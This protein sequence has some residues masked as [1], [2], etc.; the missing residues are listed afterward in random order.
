[1]KIKGIVV[2]SHT[3]NFCAGPAALPRSVL[4]K[5]QQELL[6]WQGLGVSVMEVSHRS[7]EYQQLAKKAE[8]NFRQLMNIGQDYDV[9]FLHGGASLQ[10][11]NIPMVLLDPKKEAEYL[12]NGIWSN[13]AAQEAKRF[14]LVNQ[15]E[16]L[17]IDSNGNRSL[18]NLN[19]LQRSK[20]AVYTHYTPNETIEGLRYSEIPSAT[21]ALVADL[22]SS[23]LSEVIDINQFDLIY[24]GAQKNIG[25]A[26]A[27]IVLI[28]EDFLAT[29]NADLPTMLDYGTHTAKLFNTPP[30]FAVYMVEKV[31]RWLEGKGGIQGIG[32][33]NEEKASRLYG[34]IDAS[35]F[36]RGTADLNSRSSCR[37]CATVVVNL[38]C[39]VVSNMPPRF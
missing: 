36:Y 29:R 30:V 38:P 11:S 27:T 16:L 18:K 17:N 10:F 19:S 12:C 8:S 2:I 22:S 33:I 26:G 20:R 9:L 32:Q 5:A 31:L 14:G 6:D 21:G 39:T 35:D 13:K 4:K 37:S 28:K 7:P 15:L 34:K 1:M 3:Y 25:P 23:I 24:A